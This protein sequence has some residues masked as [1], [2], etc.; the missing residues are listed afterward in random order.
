M[1]ATG[2]PGPGRAER[3]RIRSGRQVNLVVVTS[4][5]AE[6]ACWADA[7]AAKTLVGEGE[8]EVTREGIEELCRSGTAGLISFGVG[9][10]LG[11][12]LRPGDLVIADRV[13][14]PAGRSVATDPA[15]RDACT[16]QLAGAGRKV[17]VA[18]VAGMDL[19]PTSASAKRRV[20]RSTCAAVLDGESHLVAEAAE[21]RALPL[22]VLRAVADPS[23][24]DHLRGKG[25]GFG[26]LALVARLASRPL[27]MP[28]TWRFARHGRQALEG[29]QLAATLIPTPV[30]AP[31]T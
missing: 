26:S 25:E 2:L 17:V 13:A 16:R 8:P 21:A 18:A 15:W 22:L 23:W 7:G 29:L 31:A 4:S 6:A 3:N 10:G 5:H 30:L 14:L 24:D 12:A 9:A 28:A 27:D 19:P 1:G 20:F 11:P